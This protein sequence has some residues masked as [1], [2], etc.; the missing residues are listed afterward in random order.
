MEPKVKEKTDRLRDVV[1]V[2][3]A[4]KKVSQDVRTV[5]LTEK[6]EI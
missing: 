5:V 4:K 2:L 3:E 6:R 1:P